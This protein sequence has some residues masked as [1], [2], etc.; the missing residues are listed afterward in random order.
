MSQN[1]TSEWLLAAQE[2]VDEALS[3]HNYTLAEASI[4]DVSDKGYEAEAELM[5]KTMKR[6]LLGDDEDTSI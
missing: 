3:E 2:H 1:E 5:E 6:K 4:K